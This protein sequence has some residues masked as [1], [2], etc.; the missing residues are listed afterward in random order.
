MIK[1]ILLFTVAISLSAFAEEQTD[2]QAMHE[3]HLI[4]ELQE[5]FVVEPISGG[6]RISC[7]RGT[8]PINKYCWDR[9]KN[10]FNKCGVICKK[11]GDEHSGH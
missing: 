7:P 1:W 5:D 3:V 11:I 9:A 8:Q 6:S 10:V 2:D 4:Q